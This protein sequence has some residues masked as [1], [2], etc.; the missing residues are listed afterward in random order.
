MRVN[1]EQS[2]K[3]E[4]QVT[5]ATDNEIK[6]AEKELEDLKNIINSQPTNENVVLI[7]NEKNKEDK[8]DPN[9]GKI[10]LII[11]NFY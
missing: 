3:K 9:I 5:P 11:F 4:N 8:N 10:L 2:D 6:K 7:P 1:E